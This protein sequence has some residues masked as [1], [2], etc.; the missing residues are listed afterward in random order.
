MSVTVKFVGTLRNAAGKS[1]MIIHCSP[2]FSVKNLI[3]KILLDIPDI[4]T[5]VILYQAVGSIKN[6]VLIL[7]NGREISV[8]NGLD[9]QLYNDDEVVIIPV[10][11]GG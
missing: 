11:H 1:S 10:A 2:L 9:T 7:V 8:L 3:Q 5:T 6:N 4:K